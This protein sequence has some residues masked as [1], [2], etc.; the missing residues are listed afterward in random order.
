MCRRSTRGRASGPALRR[1]SGGRPTPPRARRSPSQRAPRRCVLMFRCHSSCV[2]PKRSAE[3]HRPGAD[4][5]TPR[6]LDQACRARHAPSHERQSDHG[7]CRAR[8]G[9][10]ARIREPRFAFPFSGAAATRT[11]HASPH[12][13]RR[14]A[15]RRAPGA[16][17]SRTRLDGEL[18]HEP[19]GEYIPRLRRLVSRSCR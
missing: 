12:A 19:R 10:E 4:C 18:S 3:P 6:D 9:R 1:A 16:T 14:R 2:A 7:G 15:D 11:F 13:G 17:R 5:E 8:L